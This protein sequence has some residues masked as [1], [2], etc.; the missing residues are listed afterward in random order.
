MTDQ[1]HTPETNL[2]EMSDDEILN[3]DP[4]DLEGLEEE[5]L[6]ATETDT[7]DNVSDDTGGAESESESPDENVEAA[8]STSSEELM[9]DGTDVQATDEQ[10]ETTT[11]DQDED[12]G[13]AES[14]EADTATK[15]IDYKEEF[16]KVMAPF[17]ASKREI[18]V[19]NI[20]DARRLMQ[21]GVDYSKKMEAMKPYQRVL[22]T[23]EKNDLLDMEKVNFLIDLDKKNPD[24]IR[25]F[26]KDSEIDPMDLDLEDNAD[27]RPTDHTVGD[28]EIALDDVLEQIRD[29]DAF[30]RT[31]DTIT[32]E[33]DTASRRVLMD[34]PSVIKTINDHIGAGI[35]DQIA[36][37]VAQEKIYGRLT[38]LSDLDAYKKVG[39]AIQAEGGFKQPNP[40]RTSPPGNTDQGFSQ[41]SGSESKAG[42]NAR[43]RAA[44]PTKGNASAGKT[45]VNLGSLS[46]EEIENLDLSTL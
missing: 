29:T 16:S 46:D 28:S 20:D 35:F 1:E 21:M 26:L 30:D 22:K 37:V 23:L 11:S 17:K 31:V 40:S 15:E 24:A 10:Q 12:R 25:K 34:N 4:N 9:D 32:K 43:K 3:I 41:D 5:I 14:V 18:Q 45:K 19:N 27:Y 13:T 44:S 33:W 39:D 38:G 7:D 36:N 42:V 8:D 6:S 2:A